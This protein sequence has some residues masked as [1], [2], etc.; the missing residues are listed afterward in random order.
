MKIVCGVGEYDTEFTSE[1][2]VETLYKLAKRAAHDDR[3]LSF[4]YG[5]DA[6]RLFF[7]FSNNIYRKTFDSW[8]AR[9]YYKRDFF[10]VNFE[11]HFPNELAC[12]IDYGRMGIRPLF[13]LI[14]EQ[15]DEE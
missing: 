13:C 12:Q 15:E 11:R 4:I 5:D 10:N 3:Y 7:L 2:L 8:Y 1:T 6:T 14:L 9:G